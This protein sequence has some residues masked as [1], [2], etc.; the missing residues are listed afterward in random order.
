MMEALKEDNP[1]KQKGYLYKAI[2]GPYY[3]KYACMVGMFFLSDV[4][5]KQG[6]NGLEEVFNQVY[7][8]FVEKTV[9]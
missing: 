2:Y 8:G 3:D 6:I 7:I 9:Q 4:W 1:I 5:E